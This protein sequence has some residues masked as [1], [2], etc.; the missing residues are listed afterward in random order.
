ML[1]AILE[2]DFKQSQGS[3]IL[4]EFTKRDLRE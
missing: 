4:R 1:I 2:K 3:V